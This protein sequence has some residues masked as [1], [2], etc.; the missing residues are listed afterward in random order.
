MKNRWNRSEQSNSTALTQLIYGSHL[1]GLEDSLVLWGGGNTSV[2]RKE[3]DHLGHTVDVLRI[4][5]SGANLATVEERDFAGVKLEDMRQTYS[6]DSM[7]DESMVEFLSHCLMEPNGPRP[8]IETLLHGYIDAKAIIHSHAD[9]ILALVNTPNPDTLLEELFGAQLVRVPYIRPGFAMAKTAAASLAMNDTATGLILLN[10]GLVTWGETV[11][12]AYDRHIAY[13]SAAEEF[14]MR[15][16]PSFPVPAQ[17]WTESDRLTLRQRL[18]P[19]LRHYLSESPQIVLFNDDDA[20]KQLVSRNNIE[21]LTQRGVATPDHILYTKRTPLVIMATPQMTDSELHILI[22]QEVVKYVE[23][24]EAYFNRYQDGKTEMRDPHPIVTVVPH[25]GIFSIGETWRAAK[26]PLDIYTHTAQIINWA[27]TAGGYQPISEAF[28]YD[29]EYW[30]LE[31]YKLSLR[32]PRREL[33]GRIALITGAARGIGAE[34]ARRFIQE[35]ARVVLVDKLV[36]VIQTADSLC[37]TYGSDVALGVVA[38]V[39]SESDIIS[40]VSQAITAYGGLDILVS[41]AG[42]A[43]T[44]SL[45]DLSLTEWTKSMNI[46]ITGH[47]LITREVL[48]LMQRQAFGGSLVY[49]VSKNALVPGKEFG[50]YSVAKA[51]ETQL[52]RIAAIEYGG[53]G[54]RANMINPDAI[55]TDLWSPALRHERAQAYGID[56]DELETFYRNRTLLKRTVTASDV[57]EAALFFASSRSDKTTGCI[58]PV[59]A[60]VREGFPR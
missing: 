49:I 53:Q 26:V 51:A 41:N 33:D 32:P 35:G 54:I 15:K 3:T 20:V 11:E 24:Y 52:G 29:A 58:V 16:A 31:L 30:A 8:S 42:T 39:T 4:K 14:L 5:G 28:A 38:D 12:I 13:V 22:K 19:I 6:L 48:R 36:D 23:H 57:A 27:E 25:L 45:V 59:D 55:W 2:K 1:I 10:H 21:E 44:G 46:N 56:E 60:G 9:A 17:L 18:S 37:E 50:A 34:V 7:S 40:A 47:F 43:P